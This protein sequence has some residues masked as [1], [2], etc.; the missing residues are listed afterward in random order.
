MTILLFA[1]NASTTLAA[2]ASPS[3]TSLGLSAGSG[4]KFPSPSAGEGFVMTLVDAATGLVNEIVLCTGRSGDTVT[5]QR[6]YESTTPRSWLA[7]DIIAN[8]CTAGTQAGFVQADQ[9]QDGEYSI[10]GTVGGTANAISGTLPSGLTTL[11]AGMG[12]TF[13]AA[14][15][16]TGPTT[17]NLTLGSTATG[18]LAIVDSGGNALTAGAIPAAG[19]PVSVRYNAT[20][21]K[22]QLTQLAAGGIQNS[23]IT[24]KG[25]LI[26]GAGPSSPARLGVGS[27]GSDLSALAAAP[28]GLAY[29]GRQFAASGN[30]SFAASAASNALTIT[31]QDIFGATPSVNSPVFIPFRSSSSSSGAV[32]LAQVTGALTLVAPAGASFGASNNTP[33]RLWLVAFNNGGTVILGLINCLNSTLDIFPLMADDIQSGT[34]ISGSSTSS[35]VFYTGSAV[36]SLPMRVLG[37]VEYGSGLTTAGQ[38]ATNPT[39]VVVYGPDIK[40]PNQRVR[41]VQAS[42][43]SLVAV[44]SNYSVSDTPPTQSNTTTGISKAISPY[45]GA[46]LLVVQANIMMGSNGGGL[47][48][49]AAIFRDSSSMPLACNSSQIPGSSDH[50]TPMFTQVSVLAGSTASTTFK[51]NA[52]CNQNAADVNGMSG[53]RTFGGTSNT[54]IVIDEIMT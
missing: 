12:V 49:T 27:D 11:V 28:D 26:A 13:I 21:N 45:S 19:Y 9:F 32:S 44:P 8:F 41:R 5:V 2:P 1:N 38:Y 46:N 10:I 39:R 53:S 22:W 3:D 17:F 42:S 16:N 18:A 47:D 7:G 6:G 40:L 54:Y 52:G 43:G 29:A 35:Q 50:Q 30:H 15:A 36:A 31:L 34:V 37:Y 4:S 23:I 51:A 24:S 25:D 48:A 33:F 14:S 20:L